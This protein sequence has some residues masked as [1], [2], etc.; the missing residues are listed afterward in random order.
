MKTKLMTLTCALALALNFG[1]GKAPTT[2]A[3]NTSENGGQAKNQPAPNSPAQPAANN[4]NENGA[5]A[6]NP[7]VQPAKPLPA[8]KPAGPST[9]SFAAVS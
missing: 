4:A 5:Q 3:N 6:N 8:P 2:P 1:C 7:P 9:T